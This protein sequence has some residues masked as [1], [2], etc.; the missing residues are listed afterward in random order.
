MFFVSKSAPVGALLWGHDLVGINN[1]ELYR[2]TRLPTWAHFHP[3]KWPVVGG[4]VMPLPSGVH[5][6]AHVGAMGA[7]GPLAA[8][9]RTH[10]GW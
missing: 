5:F 9:T 10:G 1:T 7:I 3:P 4:G 8:H 6:M 2:R